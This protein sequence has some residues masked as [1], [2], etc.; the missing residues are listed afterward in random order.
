MGGNV[1]WGKFGDNVNTPL[2]ACFQSPIADAMTGGGGEVE[3]AEKTRDLRLAVTITPNCK[4]RSK[5][6]GFTLI[7]VK[8]K[9]LA[10]KQNSVTVGLET[11]AFFPSSI[12]KDL[13]Y[14][15]NAKYPRAEYDFRF[16]IKPDLRGSFV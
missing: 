5:F 14:I 3:T 6:Y 16:Q 4:G 15:S 2:I 8:N 13:L 7:N 9:S 11:R 12:I 1:V 10:P